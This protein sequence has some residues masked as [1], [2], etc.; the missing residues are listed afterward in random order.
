MAETSWKNS[1][2]LLV[3]SPFPSLS[4]FIILCI[5]VAYGCV[6]MYIYIY[7]YVNINIYMYKLYIH[8]YL[9]YVQYKG[10]IG[11][12]QLIFLYFFLYYVKRYQ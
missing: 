1:L 3:L 10:M 7:S 9:Q 12:N 8:M 4:N 11:S 2:F 5:Y 6:Y